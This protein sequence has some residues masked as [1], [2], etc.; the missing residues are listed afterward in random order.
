MV[1][2]VKSI[3]GESFFMPDI[4]RAPTVDFDLLSLLNKLEERMDQYERKVGSLDAMLK[5]EDY[6]KAI[7]G[8]LFAMVKESKTPTPAKATPKV[9]IEPWCNTMCGDPTRFQLIITTVT[10][11]F[12]CY[13]VI[14]GSRDVVELDIPVRAEII[15][16]LTSGS[17]PEVG[18]VYTMVVYGES[19]VDREVEEKAV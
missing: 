13:A 19:E 15:K 6:T 9:V 5:S 10:G 4:N 1:N 11:E 3:D 8:A 16:Q 12:E 17:L 18:S 7:A 14:D 2:E